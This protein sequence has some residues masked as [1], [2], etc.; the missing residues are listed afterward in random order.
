MKPETLHNL[1]WIPPFVIGLLS[2]LLGSSWVLSDSPWL[3]DQRANEALLQ[4]S[5]QT[6]FHASVN[7]QLPEYL[8]LAYRMFGWW[9]IN[10]GLLIMGYI[11]V[12]RMG[13]P[14]A[15]NMLHIILFIMLTGLYRIEYVYISGSPFVWL[16]HGLAVMLGISIW[17]SKKLK[18]HDT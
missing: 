9:I 8:R 10:I 6:L 1:T 4:V 15:R 11:H 7:D 13:T 17:A 16:T 5:F 14:L 2:V 18:V 12:T 3:L